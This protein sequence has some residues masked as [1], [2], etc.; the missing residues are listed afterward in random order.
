MLGNPQ[1]VAGDTKPQCRRRLRSLREHQLSCHRWPAAIT[2]TAL[3]VDAVCTGRDSGNDE[4]SDVRI[5]F[6]KND[7]QMRYVAAKPGTRNG[8]WHNE[9]RNDDREVDIRNRIRRCV[10]SVNHV[11]PV[12]KSARDFVPTRLATD[13]AHPWSWGR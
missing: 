3:L 5:R 9:I 11:P 13:D 6:V 2:D 7:E 8:K 10:D 1:H 4:W 12:V